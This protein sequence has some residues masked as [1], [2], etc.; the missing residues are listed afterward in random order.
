M[1]IEL[2]LADI[3]RM[4]RGTTRRGRATNSRLNYSESGEVAG[5]CGQKHSKI[6]R[7]WKSHH[8]TEIAFRKNKKSQWP[9]HLPPPSCFGISEK[10]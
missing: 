1:A 6:E 10:E 7:G 3:Q 9:Q 5:L 4:G 8:F 2:L